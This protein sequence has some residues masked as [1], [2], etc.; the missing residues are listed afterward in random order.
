MLLTQASYKVGLYQTEKL[1]RSIPK[2]IVNSK[3][4]NMKRANPIDNRKLIK[5]IKRITN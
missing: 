2:K 5:D 3:D 1:I 4:K